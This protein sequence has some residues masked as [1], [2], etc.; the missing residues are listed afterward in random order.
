[1]I[2]FDTDIGRFNLRSAAVVVHENNV[3]I[4]RGKEDDFWALPGGRVEF[5]ENSDQTV[6]REL[7]EELG[8]ESHVLRLLW[9]VE[10]FFVYNS[11]KYHELSYYYLVNLSNPPEI[12]VEV[13]FE[14]IEENNNAVFRW[15]AIA[16]IGNYNLCPKFLIHGLG[17]LPSATEYLQVN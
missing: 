6:R 17:D 13:D 2:S 11:V 5:F 9:H 7:E 15:V 3:L 12:E 1:M 4:H 14:G 8:L 16:K 10:N